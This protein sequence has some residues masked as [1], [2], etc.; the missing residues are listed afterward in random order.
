MKK[1]T[2]TLSAIF[3][4][5]LMA[6]PISANE[7]NDPVASDTEAISYIP[8]FHG[9]VRPRWE[10]DTQNGESRFEVRWARF[11]AEG[12]VAP[13]IGYFLQLDLCDQGVFKVHDAYVKLGLVKGLEL[14]A[15]QFR[16]PFGKEPFM[17]PQNYVFAN[18]SFMGKQMCNYRKVGA[19]LTYS[20][21]L[22]IP[23]TLEAAIANSGLTANHNT[24]SKSYMGCGRATL[25]AGDFT[26]SGGMMNIIPDATRINLYDIGTTYRNG[27][28][29][30]GAEYMMEHYNRTNRK[31]AHSWV[32]WGD[33]GR[34][35]RIGMFNRWSVQA[36]YD[37]MSRQWN[38][39][40]DSADNERR[41]RIT[42]GGTL[43]YRYKKVF[44]DIMLDYE[45]YFYPKGFAPAPGQSDKIIA[46]IAVRF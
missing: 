4:S 14:Q 15:G 10:I 24:W 34:D 44:A 22:D 16:M 33:Y 17:A 39:M 3:L 13:R 31:D 36:R 42:V 29:R 12:K 26:I 38:G 23:L 30:G 35:V 21:P 28:W 2:A 8:E 27:D 9:A 1:T 5:L 45:N 25:T 18:R 19:K 43:T 37:G 41:H 6:A 46:E 40:E 7:K 20:V 11:T 32:V